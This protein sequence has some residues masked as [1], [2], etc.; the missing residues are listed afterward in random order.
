MD[1]QG[2]KKKS[3]KAKLVSIQAFVQSKKNNSFLRNN[4]RGRISV[5]EMMGKLSTKA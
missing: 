2:M 3:F 5:S 1:C 4:T